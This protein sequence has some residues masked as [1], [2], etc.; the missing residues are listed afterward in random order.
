MAKNDPKPDLCFYW[1]KWTWGDVWIVLAVNW[2]E[3]PRKRWSVFFPV[4]SKAHLRL[5]MAA[6]VNFRSFLLLLLPITLLCTSLICVPGPLDEPWVFISAHFQHN[7]TFI[8]VFFL[9]CGQFTFDASVCSAG[10]GAG[11]RYFSPLSLPVWG[12]LINFIYMGFNANPC[13]SILCFGM[14][15]IIITERLDSFFSRIHYQF[16]TVFSPVRRWSGSVGSFL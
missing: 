10:A 16:L 9:P 5:F 4:W 12:L 8:S 13:C 3:N 14:M 7:M 15:G 1:S 11:P 6:C 2:D